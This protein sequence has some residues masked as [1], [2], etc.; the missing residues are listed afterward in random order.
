[1]KFLWN[2]EPLC[3]GVKCKEGTTVAR[4]GS[5]LAEVGPGRRLMRRDVRRGESFAC[6]VGF[7]VSRRLRRLRASERGA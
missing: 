6:V 2:R 5:R 3:V 7:V 1:M 4:S